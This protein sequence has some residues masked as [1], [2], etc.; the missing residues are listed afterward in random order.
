LFGSNLIGDYLGS[1]ISRNKNEPYFSN[2]F[3]RGPDGSIVTERILFDVIPERGGSLFTGGG[4]RRG[5]IL[6]QITINEENFEIDEG[7]TL[8]SNLILQVVKF[9]FNRCEIKVV[10]RSPG[11]IGVN[12]EI[13]ILSPHYDLSHVLV[14]VEQSNESVNKPSP[15]EEDIVVDDIAEFEDIGNEELNNSSINSLPPIFGKSLTGLNYEEI[16]IIK[17]N[18]TLINSVEELNFTDGGDKEWAEE[19]SEIV[20][21]ISHDSNRRNQFYIYTVCV[22][23]FGIIVWKRRN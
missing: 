14:D 17:L 11:V 4:V 16:L 10:G 5:E 3:W 15:D 20:A 8:Y 21:G 12:G 19:E 13:L 9:D 2:N 23:I 1:V 7:V 6:V 18:E 22:L